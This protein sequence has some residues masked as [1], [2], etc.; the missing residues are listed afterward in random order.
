VEKYQIEIIK[1]IKESN[2]KTG[3]IYSLKQKMERGEILE[4][5]EISAAG[6]A[7]KKYEIFQENP[8][9]DHFPDSLE[10]M[11][12]IRAERMKKFRESQKKPESED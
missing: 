4:D 5:S 12:R 11:R 9:E 3:Y 10:E 8:V 2:F 6:R 7:L 1:K